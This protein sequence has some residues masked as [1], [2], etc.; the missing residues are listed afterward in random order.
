MTKVPCQI[1]ALLLYLLHSVTGVVL[2]LPCPLDTGTPHPL[3]THFKNTALIAFIVEKGVFGTMY[4]HALHWGL[5]LLYGWSQGKGLG[6][7]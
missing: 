6:M 7:S 1:G 2:Y 3:N 4:V 5:T